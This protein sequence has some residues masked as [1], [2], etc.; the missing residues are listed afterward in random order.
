MMTGLDHKRSNLSVREKFA[1]TK[2]NV[3]KMLAGFKDGGVGGCVILST[4]NRMELY[5]SIPDED[6]GVFAL[7]KILC[8][9]LGMD[10]S[11][12]GS[13]LTEREDSR[14]I[15]HLCRVAS[16]LDSQ[17]IGD[18]QIITQ[19]RE[20]LELSRGQKCTDN[21]IE[22]LFNISIHAAKVIKT[23]I[24]I[25]S[26][27]T[28]TV[29]EKTVEKIKTMCPLSGKNALVIGSGRIGR[30]VCDLLIREGVNVTV[31]LRSHK[32][33][34]GVYIN[35][36]ANVIDYDE[37]YKALEKVDI[38]VSATSSPHLTLLQ[39]EISAL[40]Q[41]PE[42]IVDLAVPRDVE[43]SVGSIKGVAL[44][45]IDDI[46][47]GGR[48]LSAESVLMTEN[49]I[50]EHIAKYNKWKEHSMTDQ[51][52]FFPLFIDMNGKK[53][54]IIG[55][56]NIAERRVKILV[57][58]GADITVIS[59]DITEYIEQISSSNLIHLL[60]R[61]YENG[62]IATINPF[63]IIAATNDRQVNHGVMTEAK[64]QNILVSV[65]DCRDECTF[66]FPAI[67]ENDDYIAGLVSKDGDNHSGVK[68]TAEKIREV[69][70]G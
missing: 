4:C 68:R 27:G 9:A 59:P 14:V 21:Y 15:E 12:Y 65:A 64:N 30:Q 53:V 3:K 66:Y 47:G 35:D 51:K 56:G 26:L 44:L 67:A 50:A 8:D 16:G 48:S 40:K 55:G 6:N 57:S 24:I 18:D 58:F 5:A 63:L 32:G 60:R 45:T 2:A 23:K 1:A 29:P 25:N 19:V 7:S 36:G 61:R 43:Q 11:E 46:S 39:S 34:G 13:H 20:A 22:T 62:D 28:S 42:I 70:D 52:S 31:T 17:I 37:R 49:I 10:F 54:L 41:A 69:I 38:A 33:G